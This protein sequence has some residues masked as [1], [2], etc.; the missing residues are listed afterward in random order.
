MEF[1]TGRRLSSP[2]SKGGSRPARHR[3]PEADSGEAGGGILLR[4]RFSE[5]HRSILSV[6]TKRNYPIPTS[7]WVL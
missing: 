6:Q 7:G 2:F 1:F 5:D 4:G 3:P